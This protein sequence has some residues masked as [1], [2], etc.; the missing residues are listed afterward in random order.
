A[1]VQ[2]QLQVVAQDILPKD[3][4]IAKW[5]GLNNQVFAVCLIRNVIETYDKIEYKIKEKIEICKEE[6]VLVNR[7]DFE[8][9]GKEEFEENKEVLIITNE[10]DKVENISSSIWAQVSKSLQST[11]LCKREGNAEENNFSRKKGKERLINF[12]GTK[13]LAERKLSNIK[14]LEVFLHRESEAS[15]IKKKLKVIVGLF[16]QKL[17]NKKTTT[18]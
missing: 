8:Q 4:N 9:K 12:G 13:I 2:Q 10:L 3:Q 16:I 11:V 15:S 5:L 6:E 7:L 17:K 14:F 1:K 18:S